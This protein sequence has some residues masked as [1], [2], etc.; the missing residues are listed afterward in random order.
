MKNKRRS[1]LIVL[2]VFTS[3]VLVAFSAANRAQEEPAASGLFPSLVRFQYMCQRI[4]PGKGNPNTDEI[5]GNNNGT[6]SDK[7][8]QITMNA[9]SFSCEAFLECFY[10]DMTHNTTAVGVPQG[11]SKVLGCTQKTGKLL[12]SVNLWCVGNSGTCSGNWEPS[13]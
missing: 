2:V 9:S 1:L 12:T 8:F 13:P 4:F 11:K 10:N 6:M 3:A 7:N 5:Y